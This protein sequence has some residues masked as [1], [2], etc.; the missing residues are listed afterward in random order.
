MTA[1]LGNT[2]WRDN[3]RYL[4]GLDGA[5]TISDEIT[6]IRPWHQFPQATAYYGFKL[7]PEYT[8]LSA[9]VTQDRLYA[10]PFFVGRSITAVRLAVLT[11]GNPGAVNAR[12]GIYEASAGAPGALLVDGG[13]INLNGGGV[14]EATISQVLTGGKLYW[15]AVVFAAAPAM[16][17][18]QSADMIC[19]GGRASPGDYPATSCYRAFSYAALP[20]PWGTPVWTGDSCPGMWIRI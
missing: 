8:L 6:S 3:L 10:A 15:L 11:S 4:K 20:D 14:K 19:I 13:A 16:M 18:V 12:A 17:H 7:T 5:V 2:H 1:A 9:S